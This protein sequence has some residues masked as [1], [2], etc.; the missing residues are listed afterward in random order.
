[1]VK[2]WVIFFLFLAIP[3][4]ALHAEDLQVHKDI[5]GLY[6]HILI[7][8]MLPTGKVYLERFSRSGGYDNDQKFDDIDVQ[9][10]ISVYPIESFDGQA[11]EATL[12]RVVKGKYI[13]GI[14]KDSR[15]FFHPFSKP[16]QDALLYLTDNK[17]GKSATCISFHPHR[18]KKIIYFPG[19]TKRR[20]S[21]QEYK[22][23]MRFIEETN[24]IIQESGGP[25]APITEESTILGATKK[26]LIGMEDME[27]DILL[28]V[29]ETHGFEYAATVYVV[30]FILDGTIILTKQKG[31]WDGPY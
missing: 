4:S 22:E 5:L 7:G 31:N 14:E 9:E 26:M 17:P 6:H 19:N 25:L 29:Y 18:V 10:K 15:Y 2:K 3:A 27:C 12:A 30:D 23:S 1:M 20:Y 11:F 24:R 16:T 21:V 28:S 13:G 8:E